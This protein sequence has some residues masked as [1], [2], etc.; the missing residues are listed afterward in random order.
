MLLI[1]WDFTFKKGRGGNETGRRVC[2]HINVDHERFDKCSG[3][4]A[5]EALEPTM[6]AGEP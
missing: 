4:E 2:V 6:V 5:T 3:R 1:S